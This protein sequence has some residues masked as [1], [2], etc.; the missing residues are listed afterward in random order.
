MKVDCKSDE[1]LR[2]REEKYDQFEDKFETGENDNHR[3]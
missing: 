1:I 3:H 2:E